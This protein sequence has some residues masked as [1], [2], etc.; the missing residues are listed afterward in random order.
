MY[1]SFIGLGKSRSFEA[2]V[3]RLTSDDAGNLIFHSEATRAHLKSNPQAC[4]GTE[5]LNPG[6]NY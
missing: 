3:S 6:H 1:D 5:E 2:L 4:T